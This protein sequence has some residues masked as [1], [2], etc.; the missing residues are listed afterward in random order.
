MALRTLEKG[1]QELTNS[2]PKFEEIGDYVEGNFL[3]FE[4]DDYNNKRITLWKGN[5]EET[6]EAITQMLPAVADLKRYYGQLERGMWLHIEFV[7]TIPSN[8]E[9]YSDKKIFK[10]QA[11]EERDV[12]F[13]EGEEE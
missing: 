8:N 13:D 9:N 6:G 7:K 4:I 10:V 3:G 1:G 12:V 2:Y 11:D 5:D